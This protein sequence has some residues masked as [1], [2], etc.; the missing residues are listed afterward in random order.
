[1]GDNEPTPFGHPNF[2]A[3]IWQMLRDAAKDA[4]CH[5]Y[6]DE[7]LFAANEI[8]W[9]YAEV[10]RLRAAGDALAEALDWNLSCPCNDE[11]LHGLDA[12]MNTRSLTAQRAWQEARRD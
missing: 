7:L 4:D 8:E 2:Y 11:P 9:L 12:E 5:A 3:P 10:E 1:M 6:T